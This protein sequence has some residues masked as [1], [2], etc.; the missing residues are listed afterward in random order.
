M[1]V[2]RVQ[3]SSHRRAT[4]FGRATTDADLERLLLRAIPGACALDV[5]PS[6]GTAL[7]PNL[8][9]VRPL[10]TVIALAL[11]A[12]TSPAAAVQTDF[13]G[14]DFKV[15]FDNTVRSLIGV[16]TTSPDSILGANP[17]FSASEYSFDKGDLNAAR[18]DLLSE[19]DA[20]YKQIAGAHVSFAG[21]YDLAYSKYKVTISPDL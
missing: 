7:K 13:G 10:A 6:G 20:T 21:W 16:R 18:L 3:T 19:L 14:S 2:A 12:A 4:S 15:R 5:N 17:A 9:F 11:A 8:R 1:R